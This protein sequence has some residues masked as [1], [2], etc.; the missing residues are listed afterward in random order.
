MA[1][2]RSLSTALTAAMTGLCLAAIPLLVVLPALT[3]PAAAASLGPGKN[4]VSA[5]GS[6]ANLGPGQSLTVNRALVG[7]AAKRDGSGYWLTATDG[8]IFAFGSAGFFGSMGGTPLTSPVVGIAA[9]PGGGGYWE[10][11]ADGGIFAFGDA[12]FFGSTGGHRL[13]APIVGIAAAPDGQG[14][15]LAASDGGIF[16]FGSASFHGSMGG[17]HLASPIV[18]IAATPDGGGYWLVA[19]DGGI[20]AFGNAG[21][22]GSMGGQALPAPVVGI[23][24]ASDG[25]GYW[26]AGQAGAVYAFGVPFLGSMGASPVM[27][28]AANAASGY[29]LLQGDAPIL[30]FTPGA[31]L[32]AVQQRLQDLGFW[33]GGPTGG[34]ND[35]TQQAVWAFQKYIGAPRTSSLTTDE[36]RTLSLATR[37]HD[38]GTGNMI[39]VDKS[40]E[41]VFVVQGGFT[42]WVFNTSTGG[43]YTYTSQGVTSV[44]ITPEGHFAIQYGIDGWHTS[45]LGQMWRPRFF[46]GGFA[47]HGDSSVPPVPVSHGCVRV[48]I[49]GM[50]FI[51]DNNLAP[52]GEAVWVHS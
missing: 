7:I 31:G 14:Y 3:P 9:T 49:E 6:A 15:W 13:N 10:A 16:A 40:K 43:G 34:M 33:D 51:W 25:S 8:G 44:A 35:A 47:L 24:A 26:L 32:A 46:V 20:F 41:L 27:G 2:T 23:A 17:L 18:G 42:S 50:N 12:G 22:R 37:P 21:F 48:S 29:W 5:F 4:S 52:I 36:L 1:H 11:A 28:I 39:E 30:T 38:Q 45:P 19:G